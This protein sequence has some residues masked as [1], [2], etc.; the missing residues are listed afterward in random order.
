MKQG[1]DA[2]GNFR[3]HDLL[4]G[5]LLVRKCMHTQ[6]PKLTISH[7]PLLKMIMLDLLISCL[8]REIK[9]QFQYRNTRLREELPS[10]ATR[11]WSARESCPSE[12]SFLAKSK[13][14]NALHFLCSDSAPSHPF[15]SHQESAR[16]NSEGLMC[17]LELELEGWDPSS[18]WTLGRCWL[19][20]RPLQ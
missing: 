5:I 13:G 17:F 3:S 2:F 11:L 20:I 9:A 14:L 4:K 18:A 1:N 15:S 16:Q 6:L 8:M 19:A 10:Q 7:S 12:D